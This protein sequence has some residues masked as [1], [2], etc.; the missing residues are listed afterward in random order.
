MFLKVSAWTPKLD[1]N[2]CL[3]FGVVDPLFINLGI[4]NPFCIYEMIANIK[5]LVCM[6]F[7]VVDRVSNGMG[8]CNFFGQ[9]DNLKIL[10]RAGTGRDSLSKS[11]TGRGTG[12]SLFF[13]QNPGRDRDG[14]GQSL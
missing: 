1:S 2:V 5:F 10:P 6:K 11:G 7:G 4:V 9:R 3:K 12:Q 13:Y 8:Q 14:T